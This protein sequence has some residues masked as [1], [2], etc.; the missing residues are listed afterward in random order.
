MILCVPLFVMLSLLTPSHAQQEKLLL[1]RIVK[2]QKG[3][4]EIE[5]FKNVLKFG[6]II[7]EP[8]SNV[9]AYFSNMMEVKD[10]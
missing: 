3:Q 5:P 1:N 6:Q 10:V 2:L 9:T 8:D 4:K 7:H